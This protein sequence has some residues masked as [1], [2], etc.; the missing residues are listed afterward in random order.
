MTGC[1]QS[2]R[3]SRVLPERQPL[4]NTKTGSGSRRASWLRVVVI[5]ALLVLY[6]YTSWLLRYRDS[7]DL[8]A[9]LVIRVHQVTR[10][11]SLMFVYV[12]ISLLGGYDVTE[13]R[14]KASK[15][16]KCGEARRGP[17]PVGAQAHT[18]HCG[19][20]L[21]QLFGAILPDTRRMQRQLVVG[22]QSVQRFVLA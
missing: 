5:T 4:A 13:S 3:C 7:Y 22:L 21:L 16:C 1:E 9:H 8:I 15:C 18:S 10:G 19:Q 2:R 20:L 11:S 6:S 17:W 14:E 12:R